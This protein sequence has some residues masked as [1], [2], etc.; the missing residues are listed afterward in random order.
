MFDWATALGAHGVRV[1]LPLIVLD[2]LDGLKKTGN[3][4]VST[5]ARV[6]VR[7]IQKRITTQD[8]R[9]PLDWLGGVVNVLPDSPDH[10]RLANNDWEIVDRSSY[11]ASIAEGP[12]VLATFDVG[13]RARALIQGVTL[14]DTLPSRPDPS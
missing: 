12:V 5:A 8:L 1:V 3:K 10:V 6:A 7:E 4:T 13:M 11:L 9:A 14:A 2:E